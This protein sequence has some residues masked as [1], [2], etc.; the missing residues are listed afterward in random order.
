MGPGDLIGSSERGLPLTGRAAHWILDLENGAFGELELGMGCGVGIK[1]FSG[2]PIIRDLVPRGPAAVRLKVTF[3]AD[4]ENLQDDDSEVEFV[5]DIELDWNEI[6]EMNATPQTHVPLVRF[7]GQQ[8]I[9]CVA[10]TLET[11]QAAFGAPTTAEVFDSDRDQ[12]LLE[13]LRDGFFIVGNTENGVLTSVGISS[14]GL[15]G[16]VPLR[17]TSDGPAESLPS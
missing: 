3:E 11:V 12:W 6:L 15:S 1:L 14:L 4:E 10:L 9:P 7:P 13:W 16:E 17:R 2:T 5:T 8:P